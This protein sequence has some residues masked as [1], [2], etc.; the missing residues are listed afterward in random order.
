MARVS[1]VCDA[2]TSSCITST[3]SVITKAGFASTCCHHIIAS[4]IA[5]A[6]CVMRRHQQTRALESEDGGNA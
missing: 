5:S 4:I 3:S 2:F 1:A 6:R